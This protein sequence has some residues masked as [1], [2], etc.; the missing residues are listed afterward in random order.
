MQFINLRSFV[1]IVVNIGG[2]YV[3]NNE[4]QFVYHWRYCFPVNMKGGN[5][6]NVSDGSVELENI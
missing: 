1:E 3:A 2:A 4:S 6:I 5:V